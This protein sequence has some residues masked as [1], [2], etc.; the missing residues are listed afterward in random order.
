MLSNE[1]LEYIV[2]CITIISQMISP[3]FF[4]P[5][6]HWYRYKYLTNYSKYPGYHH[7]H[8]II[9]FLDIIFVVVDELKT[10]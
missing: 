3:T 2:N 7:H 8:I 5:L 1:M 6:P 4:P 10:K 9:T